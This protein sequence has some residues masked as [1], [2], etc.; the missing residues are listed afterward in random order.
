MLFGK[1]LPDVARKLGKSY[2][3]FRKGLSEM[4]AQLQLDDDVLSSSSSSSSSYYSDDDYD[5][6]EAPTA[7]KFEPPTSEPSTEA[8][9][10]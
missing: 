10:V 5:N 4:Q 9:E 7:P 8:E 6:Y 1:N 3:Q 2:T